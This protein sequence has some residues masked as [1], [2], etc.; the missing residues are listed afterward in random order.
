M[1]Y[2]DISSSSKPLFH[3][4]ILESGAITSRSVYPYNATLH[5]VQFDDFIREVGCS[6]LAE[7]A[8]MPCLR[9]NPINTIAKASVKI[10][11]RYENSNRWAFQPVIDGKTIKMAPIRAWEAGHWAKIPIVTGF[12]T[13]DGVLFVDS[14]MDK[15]SEFIDFFHGLIPALRDSELRKLANLYP[16]PLKHPN[17]PY[18]ET[19]TINV[20]SQFKRVEAAYGQFA[21]ICPVRQTAHFAAAGQDAPVYL[22]HWALNKTVKRGTNHGGQVEYEVYSPKARR[23]STAQEKIAGYLHAYLT[24]FITTGDPNTVTGKYADRPFWQSFEATA[25]SDRNDSSKKVMLFGEGND[26]RAGGTGVGIPAQ[27]VDDTWSTE[28]C[29]FWSERSILTES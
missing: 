15:S 29:K 25:R 24:S 16:N 11:N 5:E 2:N 17:S 4:A 18:K 1:N 22:Y 26:E 8:I 14:D 20:G 27:V 21:Y 6:N 9:Q 23:I 3:R 7:E 10:F 28:Q 13:N 12:N 19:R